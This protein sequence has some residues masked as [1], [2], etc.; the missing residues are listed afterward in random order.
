M[1]KLICKGI[2]KLF[3]NAGLHFYPQM[4]DDL[5]LNVIYH[6]SCLKNANIN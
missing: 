4:L 3:V 5:N 2:Y 1:Y 6:E